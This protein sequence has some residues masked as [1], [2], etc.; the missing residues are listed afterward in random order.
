MKKRLIPKYEDEDAIYITKNTH[1]VENKPTPYDVIFNKKRTGNVGY[2]YDENGNKY[3]M[4][5]DDYAKANELYMKKVDDEFKNSSWWTR[6]ITGYGKFQEKA[7][8]KYYKDIVDL[9]N[10]F[11]YSRE[12][13]ELRKELMRDYANF[14][15]N[16]KKHL[17]W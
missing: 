13:P 16:I 12:Y 3:S 2:Y 4:D 6:N 1:F 7:L 8:K 11:K 14:S 15:N 17:Q 10:S 5:F 9:A